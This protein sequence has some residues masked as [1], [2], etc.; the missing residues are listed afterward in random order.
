[1]QV[2][3]VMIG[4]MKHV[5][6]FNANVWPHNKWS[7]EANN[8]MQLYIHASLIACTYAWRVVLYFN[9]HLNNYK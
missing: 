1:M 5:Q 8:S 4:Y 3:E 6:E 7:A 9:V 2:Q